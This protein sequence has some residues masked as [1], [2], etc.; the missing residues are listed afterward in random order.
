MTHAPAEHSKAKWQFGLK[1]GLVLI[2]T[3]AASLAWVR[4]NADVRA[5]KQEQA[6]YRNAAEGFVIEHLLDEHAAALRR[7]IE[8]ATVIEQTI[9]EI[10]EL[11]A[12]GARV[13][14]EHTVVLDSRWRG[15]DDG[16]IHLRAIDSLCFLHVLNAPIT[17]RGIPYLAQLDGLEELQLVGTD[18][19]ISGWLQLTNLN[20]LKLL[21]LEGP[22]VDDAWLLRLSNCPMLRHLILRGTSVSDAAV[23]ELRRSRPRLD[24]HHQLTAESTPT[25][26]AS[27]P[28]L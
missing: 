25:D 10:A 6:R 15:G 14:D 19:T 4:L 5:L 21:T 18:V 7:Q 11:R 24:V 20:T 17:D 3:I 28:P 2:L 22:Q 9:A 13:V 16:L 27:A 12:L 26:A 1:A 23:E 8:G